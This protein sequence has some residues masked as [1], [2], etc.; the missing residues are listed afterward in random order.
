MTI[1]KFRAPT[2]T[3]ALAK[4]REELGNEAIILS[5]RS[6]RKGGVFDLIGRRV[7]EVTAALDDK[8]LSNN[9]A[10]NNSRTLR[11]NP[12]IPSEAKL[13]PP[14][15]PVAYKPSSIQ[16]ATG[17]IE[18]SVLNDIENRINIEQVLGDI[19]DLKQSMKVLADTALTGEMSGL[20]STLASLMTNMQSSG[21]EDKIVKRIIRQL[22]D[23][24]DGVELFDPSVVLKKAADLLVNGI[25]EAI[26]IVFAGAKPRI[27][28]FVGPTGSGK[29]TTIAKLA[30]DFMLNKEKQVGI[31]TIDTK[32]VNA[33]GQLKAYCRIL[34][35]PLFVAYTPDELPSIMPGIM[36]SDITLVDTPG[37]GP[38][39][40]AQIIQMVEFL[41]KMVPQEVHLVMSVTTSLS[42]MNR[43]LNN[44]DVLKPNRILF[45][46]LDETDN[47]GPML[48]FALTVKKFMS[49]V[50]FGQ[51]IPGNF[52]LADPRSLIQQNLVGDN[53]IKKTGIPEI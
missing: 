46:K 37:S 17:K 24:L 36:N 53:G 33:M 9:G 42:E 50:T 35:I 11:S 49:Y 6:E 19:K 30:A 20:P 27:V 38:I 22:L 21:M 7:V 39:D 10:G 1:K 26:P 43:I 14:K 31:L 28:V 34:N 32:R 51:E 16:G 47:Y 2:V 23:E 48:S 13:Y 5:T 8:P 25:G 3:E 12:M 41:Q 40:E 45:T 29:T 4:V 52:S 15:P 18:N 44:F